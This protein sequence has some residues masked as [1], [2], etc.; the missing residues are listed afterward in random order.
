MP[1]TKSS[2]IVIPNFGGRRLSPGQTPKKCLDWGTWDCDPSREGPPKGKHAYG[3]SFPWVFDMEEKAYILEGSAVLTSDD[4]E[5]IKLVAK[6]M[7][8]F[9]KGWS[10]RWDVESFFKKKYAF[11]NKGERVDESSEEE[12]E[13]ESD[14]ASDDKINEKRKIVE[15]PDETDQKVKKPKV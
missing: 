10:G 6:D 14:G 13:E 4:G 2:I 8:T 11:F 15:E 1:T 5:V 9:P 3:K 7:V 12:S